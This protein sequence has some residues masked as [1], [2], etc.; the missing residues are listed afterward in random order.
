MAL[1]EEE[2]G[3]VD[4]NGLWTDSDA[5][6]SPN[7]HYVFNFL[8]GI[9]PFHTF[10]LIKRLNKN[11]Q[12]G[13][14]IHIHSAYNGLYKDEP[15]IV[16]DNIAPP[17]QTIDR[18]IKKT[19]SI[20]YTSVCWVGSQ[21]PLSLMKPTPFLVVRFFAKQ[22]KSYIILSNEEYYINLYRALG[23]TTLMG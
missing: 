8:K 2:L 19:T 9:E 21:T 14:Y 18:V 5:I 12:W 16:S 10:S 4:F 20:N 22:S 15:I 23:K 7:E 17:D 13:N 3:K 6:H 1:F 11:N